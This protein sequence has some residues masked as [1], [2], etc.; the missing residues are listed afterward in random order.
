MAGDHGYTYV[1]GL[2]QDRSTFRAVA[3]IDVLNARNTPNTSMVKWAMPAGD[4]TVFTMDWFC[5]RQAI[6]RQAGALTL[7]YVGP[8]G[9]EGHATQAGLGQA[10]VCPEGDGP[11]VHGV[12]RDLQTIGEAVYAV[13][14]GRQV[15]R[16]APGGQWARHDAGVLQDAGSL[17]IVGFNAIHGLTEDDLYAVGFGGEIWRRHHDQWQAIDSPSRVILNAVHVLPDARVLV[18]GKQGVLILGAGRAWSRLESGITTEI[19]DIHWFDG[20][21]YLATSD[22]LYRLDDDFTPQRIDMRLGPSMT[23]GQLHADGGVLLSTGRK[24]Q[25]WSDDGAVWHDIT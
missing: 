5:T 6:C 7:V 22:A 4:R 18:A 24:H 17:E 10:H 20:H 11:D 2:V 13:G 16:R 15:Y 12:I 19:W 23:C 3:Q 8:D 21:V 9:R 14:M 1:H 25:C